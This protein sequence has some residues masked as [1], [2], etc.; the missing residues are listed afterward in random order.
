[1]LINTAT[2]EL[3]KGSYSLEFQLTYPQGKVIKQEKQIYSKRD[4]STL[5][6]EHPKLWWPRGYGDQPLYQ[7]EVRLMNE[8]YQCDSK[9]YRIGLRTL[10]ISQEKDEWGR[11]FAFMVNGVKIFAKGANYIPED[12]IYPHISHERISYLF[13]IRAIIIASYLGRLL[14]CDYFKDL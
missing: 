8:G 14:P 5:R 7:L 13:C 9:G 3:T 2:E 1:M 10:T 6:V 11:E 12:T 4:I